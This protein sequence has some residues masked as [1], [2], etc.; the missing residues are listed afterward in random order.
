MRQLVEQSLAGIC[1]IQD[2]RT[3]YANP[4]MAEMLGMPGSEA[5]ALFGRAVLDFVHPDDHGWLRIADASGARRGRRCR[6]ATRSVCC[7]P[8]G[9]S[10]GPRSW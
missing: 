6:S 5:G 10:P 7:E 1:L 2:E 3:L 8:T 4:R 9:A